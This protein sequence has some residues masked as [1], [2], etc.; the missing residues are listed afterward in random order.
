M[1]S[2]KKARKAIKTKIVNF[3]KNIGI[4]RKTILTEAGGITFNKYTSN[5]L[6]F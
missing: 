3:N 2:K 6:N 4:L 1:K 5:E